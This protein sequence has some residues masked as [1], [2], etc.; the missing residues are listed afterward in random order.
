LGHIC[1]FFEKE[2]AAFTGD[3]LFSLGCGR[4]FEGDHRQ[5]LTSL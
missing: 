1:F 4:I 2:K 5:M 3:T